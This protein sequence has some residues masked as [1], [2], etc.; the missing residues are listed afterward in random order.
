MS[1]SV[2]NGYTTWL[3]TCPTPVP[4]VDRVRLVLSQAVI[5]HSASRGRAMADGVRGT[6]AP[7][8]DRGGPVRER[9]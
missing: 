3:T 1:T 8:L 4:T 5:Q 7:E 9:A 2:D 6:Y